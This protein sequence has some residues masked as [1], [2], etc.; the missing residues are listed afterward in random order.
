MAGH[1][2][3]PNDE[4]IERNVKPARDLESDRH[5]A[6]RQDQDDDV[7]SLGVRCFPIQLGSDL[8]ARDPPH[9]LCGSWDRHNRLRDQL[10]DAECW[11]GTRAHAEQLV[12]SLGQDGW[13]EAF[14]AVKMATFGTFT[15]PTRSAFLATAS[16][17]DISKK[18]PITRA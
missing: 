15:R 16:H 14:A 18:Y 7:G 4:H 5:A 12:E 17:V 8:I 1:T 11:L 2:E 9:I 13:R 3:L 10:G 6:A